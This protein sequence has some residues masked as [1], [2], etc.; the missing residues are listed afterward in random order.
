MVKLRLSRVGR[1]HVQLFRL[2]AT[3]SRSPRDGKVLEALGT[4]N[5]KGERF[6]DSFSFK[7]DRVLYWL[8]VGAQPSDRVWNMLRKKGINKANYRSK[9]AAL[10]KSA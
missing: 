3:D 2:V 6:D 10:P 4:Y 9:I 7:E 5:P 1:L 8:S